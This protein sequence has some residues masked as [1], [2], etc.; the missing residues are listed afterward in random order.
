M[1]FDNS[2]YIYGGCLGWNLDLENNLITPLNS[3]L[4]S[5]S[6]SSLCHR[7]SIAS[8][9][10]EFQLETKEWRPVEVRGFN[11]ILFYFILFYFLNYESTFLT[12]NSSNQ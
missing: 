2:F 7:L 4:S 11:F 6:S 10:F 5:N 9:C 3:N 1:A 8:D 12:Q